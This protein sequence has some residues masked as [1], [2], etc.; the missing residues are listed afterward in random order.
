MGRIPL[1][2]VNKSF[3]DVTIIPAA[4]LEIDDG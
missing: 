1:Q 4:D 2:G 3:G